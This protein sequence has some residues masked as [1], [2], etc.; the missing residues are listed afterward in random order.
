MHGVFDSINCCLHQINV[1][2]VRRR[3]EQNVL[4]LC[5]NYISKEERTIR[6]WHDT[7]HVMHT[8]VA[9]LWNGRCHLSQL[10]TTLKLADAH[11]TLCPT[12]SESP[13][14]A[15]STQELSALLH[16]ALA[17]LSLGCYTVQHNTFADSTLLLGCTTNF[18]HSD[19]KHE[20]WQTTY[21]YQIDGLCTCFLGVTTP[22]FT[23]Q[24]LL[25]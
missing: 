7:V 25:R 2:K 16:P 15:L 14:H 20:V 19:I 6:N 23:P 17:P 10:T 9:S 8:Y 3:N 13:H 18:H 24:P 5:R 1:H 22:S 21:T 11:Y 12:T 4:F